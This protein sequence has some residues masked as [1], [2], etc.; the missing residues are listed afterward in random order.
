V[1]LECAGGAFEKSVMWCVWFAIRAILIIL[2]KRILNRM[3]ARLAFTCLMEALMSPS[4]AW[5][6]PRKV[7]GDSSKIS[8]V[9]QNIGTRI[10]EIGSEFGV[11]SWILKTSSEH[12]NFNISQGFS[13]DFSVFQSKFRKVH[14]DSG[15]LQG[16]SSQCLKI[17]DVLELVSPL[18]ALC[19]P[20]VS[21]VNLFLAKGL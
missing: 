17:S 15:N 11:G 9:C 18:L 12:Q 3:F 21:Y 1:F 16:G 6:L 19:S 5:H 14:L 4:P 20:D 2:L 10:P 13:V 8:R 7:P